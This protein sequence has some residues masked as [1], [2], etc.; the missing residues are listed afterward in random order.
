M[1]VIPGD[2]GLFVS[3]CSLVVVKHLLLPAGTECPIRQDWLPEV[4]STIISAFVTEWILKL[5]SW[6]FLPTV[7]AAYVWVCV[8]VTPASVWCRPVLRRQMLC[9]MSSLLGTMKG[10]RQTPLHPATAY[11]VQRGEAVVR[12]TQPSPPYGHLRPG[13]WLQQDRDG[14]CSMM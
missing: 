5:G 9:H 13:P 4:G 2:D 10:A 14:D 7:L 1:D 11:G 3:K 8:V 6:T 12:P